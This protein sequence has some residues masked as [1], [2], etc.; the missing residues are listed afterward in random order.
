MT[1]ISRENGERPLRTQDILVKSLKKKREI[2]FP[3][4]FLMSHCSRIF[5]IPVSLEVNLCTWIYVNFS[6]FCITL[7]YVTDVVVV[8]TRVNIYGV[9]NDNGT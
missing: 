2:K 4:R 3:C 6:L 7:C 1:Y 5:K 8:S 9:S